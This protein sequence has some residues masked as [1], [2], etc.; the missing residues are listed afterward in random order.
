M[1]LHESVFAADPA[2]FLRN[3]S[4]VFN[5]TSPNGVQLRVVCRRGRL[6]IVNQMRLPETE[7]TRVVW[8]IDKIGPAPPKKKKKRS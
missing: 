4:G 8:R 5:L 3:E 7:R 6:R 1:K 2:Q